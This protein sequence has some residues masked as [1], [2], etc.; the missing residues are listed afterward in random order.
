MMVESEAF[1]Y[2][3][4]HFIAQTQLK[5]VELFEGRDIFLVGGLFRN[6]IDL[7]QHVIF[8]PIVYVKLFLTSCWAR[9]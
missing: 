3:R 6:R 2:Q 8:K 4:V 7:E 1:Q 5:G 9:K